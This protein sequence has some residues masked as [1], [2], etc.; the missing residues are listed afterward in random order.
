MEECLG[1]TPCSAELIAEEPPDMGIVFSLVDRDLSES[2]SSSC[3]W[4][5]SLPKLFTFDTGEFKELARLRRI[6]LPG[7][8][9][10]VEL[11]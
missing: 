5:D 1:E 2:L 11:Y 10:T 3:P 4:S 7:V 6:L 8:V 9:K